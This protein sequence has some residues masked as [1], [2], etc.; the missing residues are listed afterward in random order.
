MNAIDFSLAQFDAVRQIVAGI[1]PSACEKLVDELQKA[2]R[3]F[4]G[5]A[6]RSLLS[7]KMFA[8]RLMQTGHQTFLVGEVC[9][10]SIGKGDLL[11]TASGSG[12]T[13][14][15]LELVGKARKNG[16]R[17]ALITANPAGPIATEADFVLPVPK[18]PEAVPERDSPASLFVKGN[19]TGNFFEA[20]VIAV[21]DGIIARIMDREG[22]TGK[23]IRRN[24]A[25]LE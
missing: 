21:T 4:V 7:V 18:T 15:T 6:G 17:A 11:V 8:M 20:A 16:A 24:H 9:T 1:D 3:V 5:G 22:M 10:P 25:N 19:L 14:G 23:T 13:P 12:S 2:E